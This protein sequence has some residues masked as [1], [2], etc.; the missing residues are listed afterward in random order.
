MGAIA[1]GAEV[2]TIDDM[3]E[4][5]LFSDAGMRLWRRD[6]AAK[7]AGVEAIRN[8]AVRVLNADRDHDLRRTD[9]TPNYTALARAIVAAHDEKIGVDQDAL[10]RTWLPRLWSSILDRFVR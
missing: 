7:E 1:H 6:T 3:L 8:C 9:G 10:R 4:G 2:D 5:T